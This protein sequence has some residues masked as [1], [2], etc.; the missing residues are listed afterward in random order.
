MKIPSEKDGSPEVGVCPIP[1]EELIVLEDTLN[2]RDGY[3]L[4]DDGCSTN[5]VS[6]DF[7]GK[8]GSVFKIED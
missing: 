3:I 1:L 5:I 6:K 8:N 7:V 4:K 2:G